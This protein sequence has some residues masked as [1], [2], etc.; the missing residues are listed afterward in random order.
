ML[1]F[2]FHKCLLSSLEA[3]LSC[4]LKSSLNNFLCSRFI[5]LQDD[6]S[7]IKMMVARQNPL[8]TN[9]VLRVKGTLEQYHL[10]RWWW[11][12]NHPSL[13]CVWPDS[14]ILETSIHCF[15][16]LKPALFFLSLKWR[17]QFTMWDNSAAGPYWILHW[18]ATKTSN[19]GDLTRRQGFFLKK[20]CIQQIPNLVFP[21]MLILLHFRLL[22]LKLK[23]QE[24]GGI[25][26]C[27]VMS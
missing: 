1:F 14:F 13:V 20:V 16:K 11:W 25:V 12:N 21:L 8:W 2:Y 27:S 18:H 15:H 17:K 24:H 9:G 26:V 19:I 22:P 4:S 10:G 3:V 6:L 23:S 7:M 5:V